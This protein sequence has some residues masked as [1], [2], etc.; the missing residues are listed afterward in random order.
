MLVST[1]RLLQAARKGHYAIGAFNVYNLEGAKAVVAAAEAETAPAMLQIHPSALAYGGRAL[2]ELCL[3]AA[4]EAA[5]P[6][7][8][9]LDHSSAEEAIRAALAAGISSIMADGSHLDFEQNV[10]FTRRMTALAHAQD[11][12]VEA[13]LGRISG[14]EDGLTVP[15]FEARFTDPEGAATF[16]EQTGV[17]ALAVCIGNVHGRYPRPPQLDFP[18]LEAV[19]A[20]VDVPLVLHGASGIPDAMVQQAIRSGITKLNVNTEVRNAYLDEL[21]ARLNEPDPPDLLPLMQHAVAAM[22]E[23]VAAKIRMF[24]AAGKA[25]SL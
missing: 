19:R 9:H 16:V 4:A 11:V 21:Q 14:T 22:Q 3:A 12:A 18:R 25:A 15:E 1:S 20:A 17:D 13:E 6:M 2:V 23:V 8:V 10:A 24:G 7:A 5:V